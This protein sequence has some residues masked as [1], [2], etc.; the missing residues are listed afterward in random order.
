VSRAYGV[1]D[2]KAGACVRSLFVL[3]ERGVI[4]WSQAYPAGV[5]PGVDGI[6]T[7][8]E[9]MGPVEDATERKRKAPSRPWRSDD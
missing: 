9:T 1:Y 2:Q 6:L 7:A 8:L 4:R 5:N 3:E